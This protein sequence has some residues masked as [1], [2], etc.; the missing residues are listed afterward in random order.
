MIVVRMLKFFIYSF[1]LMNK[2]G[3]EIEIEIVLKNNSVKNKPSLVTKK[4]NKQ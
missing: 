2:N 4:I 1:S 3:C